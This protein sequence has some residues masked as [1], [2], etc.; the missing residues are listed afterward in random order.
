MRYAAPVVLSLL[1][2]TLAPVRAQDVPDDPDEALALARKKKAEGVELLKKARSGEGD[3]RA[4]ARKAMGLFEFAMECYEV[5][6]EKK[7]ESEEIDEE[8]SELGSLI[9]WT[10]KMTPI[11]E[12]EEEKEE[13]RKA[14]K[15]P[16][17][18]K[19]R[20]DDPPDRA[21][22]RPAPPRQSP[23]DEAQSLFRKAQKFEQEHPDQYL[24]ISARYFE[25]VDKFRQ[26]PYASRALDKCMEYQRKLMKADARGKVRDKGKAAGKAGYIPPEDL[27][28]VRLNFRHSDPDIRRHN[29]KALVSI[30]G[31]KS[32]Y[33]LHCLFTRES[34]SRV[35]GS[36][37]DCLA[38]FR[39]LYTLRFLV[40]K[41][42]GPDESTA[43]KVIRL[44]QAVGRAEWVRPMLLAI[45]TNLPPL[46]P[47]TA[48]EYVVMGEQGYTP[49]W[50]SKVSAAFAVGLRQTAAEAL[51]KM[52]K[53]GVR[54]LVKCTKEK[55]QVGREAV[56]LLGVLK[57]GKSAGYVSVFLQRKNRFGLR[58]E[59]MAS[60]YLIGT[61]AVPYLI[62]NLGNSEL[63]TWS[64]YMLREIT[65][66]PW[67]QGHIRKWSAW[68]RE[69]KR[70]R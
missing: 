25:I 30:L 52:G 43:A 11:A 38:G 42:A 60:V 22:G 64:A 63:K 4:L 7:G 20:P 39:D 16:P 31:R 66:M 6:V 34:H 19:P 32:L 65:G 55:G 49:P 10:R 48:L 47:D 29:V 1:L 68:Y 59:A 62:K 17:A 24:E 15:P 18:A 53:N 23:R 13:R 61:D 8:M 58:Y 28:L 5:R 2:V 56:L 67:G 12:E 27:T 35:L 37:I 14:A 51:G 40:R 69:Q 54:G 44:C 50:A 21:T 33:D 3:S 45:A 41:A 36:I 26:S 9:Y 46:Q 70:G 57:S